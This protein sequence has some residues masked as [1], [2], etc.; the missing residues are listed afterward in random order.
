MAVKSKEITSREEGRVKAV[1]R[2]RK[3]R[4]SQ[5]KQEETFSKHMRAREGPSEHKKN[6]T[7][8]KLLSQVDC[9]CFVAHLG[10]NS[11][12]PKYIS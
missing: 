2:T 1:C 3:T 8:K 6:R 7:M 12:L 5:R 11:F 9:Y 4:Q 10:K